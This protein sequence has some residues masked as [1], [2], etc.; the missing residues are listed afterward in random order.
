MAKKITTKKLPKTPKKKFGERA[1]TLGQQFGEK[2][3][4]WGANI[5]S[6]AIG[7]PT[8]FVNSIGTRLGNIGG[9]GLGKYTGPMAEF[10]SL[11]Y[12]MNKFGPSIGSGVGGMLESDESK[13]MRVQTEADKKYKEKI[14][15]S[16]LNGTDSFLEN[17]LDTADQNQDAGWRETIAGIDQKKYEEVASKALKD[18]DPQ[19]IWNFVVREARAKG[20]KINM[21]K[22][23]Y[24]PNTFTKGGRKYAYA[25]D[26]SQKDDNGKR[27]LKLIPIPIGGRPFEEPEDAEEVGGTEE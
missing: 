4:E 18:E 17:D 10:G 19:A 9:M 12:L 20:K 5:G 14:S 23:V 15:E 21:S 16:I 27:T 25:I 7:F 8:G 2:G 6:G 24:L 26:P 1:Y 11:A 13:K 22:P 3:G